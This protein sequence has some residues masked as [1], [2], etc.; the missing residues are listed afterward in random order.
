MATLYSKIPVNGFGGYTPEQIARGL[1]KEFYNI[2]RPEQLHDANDN[3]KYLSGWIKHPTTGQLA[4]KL[5]EITIQK[6]NL[7]DAS[8]LINFLK[9]VLS[10][11]KKQNIRDYW[12]DNQIIAIQQLWEY[13]FP[14]QTMTRAEMEQEGWFATI[15]I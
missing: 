14:A 13:M 7:A 3:T 12:R 8:K 4:I 15:E 6:H 2:Q 9:D 11:T 1:Q 10:D 5:P